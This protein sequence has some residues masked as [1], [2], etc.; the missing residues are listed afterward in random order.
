M[1]E[2]FEAR[3]DENDRDRPL[4][5]RRALFDVFRGSGLRP[6][7]GVTKKMASFEFSA[8]KRLLWEIQNPVNV[9]LHVK[10]FDRAEANGFV[11]ELRPY[12]SGMKDGGRHSALSRDWSFG[13]ADCFVLRIENAEAL[14]RLLGALLEFDNALVLDPAAVVRWIERLRHFFPALDGFDRP[15]PQ[16]DEAE[17]SYKLDVAVELKTAVTQS[18]SDQELADAVN[19]ALGKSNLLQWRTYWPMSPKGDADRERLWP[20]LRELLNAALGAADGHPVA[21]EAFAN[22]WIASVPDAKPDAARQIGEFLFLH[23][24][25]DAGIYIRHSVRQ[26]LWLEAVGSRFPDHTSMADTYRDEWRFM[27][28]V[29]RAFAAQ[30]LAPRDMIDVQSALWVV[31]NYKEEDVEAFSRDAIEAAMDAFDGY[32]ESGEHAAI[33]GS[34]GEPRDLWVRSTKDRPNRVYPTKPIV[35]YLLGHTDIHGGWN[36]PSGPAARL[37]NSGYIITDH[38]DRPRPIPDREFLVRGADRIRSCARN[39][40]VA[41]A[42]EKG[43]A[44]VAIRAGDLGRDMALHD[45][46]PAICSALGSEEFQRDAQ[47]SRPTHTLPNPSIT[48]VFTYQLASAEGQETMTFEPAIEMANT[49]NLILYGPPGTGK[50]Y[51]TAWEAVRLCLGDAAAE[52]LRG[53]RHDLMTE[54][55]RLAKEGRIEFVTFH[56]SFSY[57]DFVEGLRPTTTANQEGDDEDAST[58]GGFSLDPH[59]GVFKVISEKARLDTGDAPAK[60]LDRSR[61]IYKIALGQRDSQEDRIREGLDSGLIHLGWGGDINWSDERFDDFEEIRKTWNEQKDAQASGKDPNIE[62]LYAFRS[63]LQIGDYVVISDGRDS[64]RAF[65]RVSGE[66]YFDSDAEFHPHRRKVEWI[67]RNDD[68]AKR[69]PF[70]SRNFRRQSAYRLD[71]S[72]IDWDAVEAVVIDPNAELPMSS[73]RPHVLIIDEINRA[74]ISKVFGELITLLEVDKRLGCKNEVRVRLPYSGTSFGVPANLHIIGTMNTADRSI[75]LL[76]TALRRRFTF[77][78]LMPDVEELRQAMA[79]RQLDATNLDGIDICKLLQTLNERIEYLFDREH[80]I[81][82]AYFTGCTTRADVEDVMRHKVIPL[83]AE[84]FYEDWSKVAAVLGDGDGTRGSHFLEAKRLVAPAG[85]ADDELGGDKLRWSVKDAFDFS[86]FSA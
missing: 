22:V 7:D 48:T 49:T 8:G 20:A 78:E 14:R 47:V 79:A 42:R 60:R 30:G 63:G 6:G 11:G 61:S 57:E 70:Y 26:D 67:W 83:L 13:D 33:F 66:Y 36:R 41:P 64:Y 44:E 37:H 24:A 38:A 56:Q 84:Y 53:D 69:A 17:R 54:Y 2:N 74:N 28:A 55:H 43:A 72:Q 40:Y 21:L 16:F 68:G 10:W 46:H 62:V 15:D 50:T 5:L 81:G 51:A 86:D 76:D 73:A 77:R 12:Q 65:G 80:Q 27:E 45:R 82:H 71:P 29:R 58:S 9:F 35:A 75:A 52:P 19:T 1:W 32:P 4:P 3:L 59:D 39:Y 25:P 23:L 85:F 18:R 34:F 31:H